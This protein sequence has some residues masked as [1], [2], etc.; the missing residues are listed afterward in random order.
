MLNKNLSLLIGGYI[1]KNYFFCYRGCKSMKRN[2]LIAVITSVIYAIF[3][4]CGFILVDDFFEYFPI[5]SIIYISILI[6]NFYCLKW[7]NN[8][9]ADFIIEKKLNFLFIVFAIFYLVVL[10]LSFLK[11]DG[12][13]RIMYCSIW[14]SL[15]NVCLCNLVYLK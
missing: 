8:F 15:I 11:T 9:L 7:R 1:C 4:A 12:L 14:I 10:I 13:D 2:I 3:I 6:L 5:S